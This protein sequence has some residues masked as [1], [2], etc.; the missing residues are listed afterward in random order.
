MAG[1]ELQPGCKPPFWPLPVQ[2]AFVV[3]YGMAI[4]TTGSLNLLAGSADAIRFG[5]DEIMNKHRGIA[6]AITLDSD[7]GI[8]IRI[9]ICRGLVSPLTMNQFPRI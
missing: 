6:K 7:R 3:K 8:T 2:F 1:R 5:E 4:F 9:P